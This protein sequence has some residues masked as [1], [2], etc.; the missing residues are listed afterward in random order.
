M[1]VCIHMKIQIFIA[2]L[3]PLFVC[4]FDC[5]C[6]PLAL[7]EQNYRNELTSQFNRTLSLCFPECT[8]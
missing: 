7:K 1:C 6:F 2:A 4:L 5:F 3:L 8:M